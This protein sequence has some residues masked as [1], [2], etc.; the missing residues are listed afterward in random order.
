MVLLNQILL[1]FKITAT[2][3]LF[4]VQA[5]GQFTNVITSKFAQQLLL[6]LETLVAYKC[7][8]GCVAR[9]APH[10]LTDAISNYIVVL[11]IERSA[12]GSRL[13]KLRYIHVEFLWRRQRVTEI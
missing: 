6:L 8:F 1:K 3:I 9:H 5:P 2:V 13:F 10:V 7:F 12:I 11:T 4:L